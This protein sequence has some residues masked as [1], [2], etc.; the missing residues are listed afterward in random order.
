MA[1]EL[2]DNVEI[3]GGIDGFPGTETSRDQRR[4]S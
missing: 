1:F 3:L 2:L 4:S